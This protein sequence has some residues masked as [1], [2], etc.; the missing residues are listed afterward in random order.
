LPASPL[1]STAI[2][3][4]APAVAEPHLVAADYDW[5]VVWDSLP[6]LFTAVRIT[7]VV[8][9]I[10]A[11]VAILLGLLVALCRLTRFPPLRALAFLYTQ[12]FRGIALYVL[13]GWIWFGLA[14]A[15]GLKLEAQVAG[16]VALSLL[17]SAYLAE[18]FRGSIQAVDRGQRDAALA[19]GLSRPRAFTSVT[20]PQAF[21][22]AL[23]ATTNQLIDIVKDSSILAVIGVREL[24]RETQRLANQHFRPFE[25]YTATMGMYLGLVAIVSF[26]MNRVEKALRVNERGPRVRGP[27]LFSRVVDRAAPS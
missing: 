17:N 19:L 10:S 24:M 9:L 26:V 25:F 11:A 27:R 14:L 22:V 20:L 13:L 18:I 8:T 7:I 1:C 4:G 5:S 15:I 21:R 16:I 23:P 12:L 6:V 2:S 3:A